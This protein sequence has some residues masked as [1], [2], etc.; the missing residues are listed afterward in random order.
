MKKEEGI[1]TAQLIIA[2]VAI[3]CIICV[4]ITIRKSNNKDNM[5][6]E[7]SKKVE[8]VQQLEY[9]MKVNTFEELEDVKTVEGLEIR[10]IQVTQEDGVSVILADI[11]NNTAEE[12]GGFMVD[13]TFTDI[14]GSVIQ[15]VPGYIKNLQAGETTQLN[16]SGTVELVETYNY[17]I[18]KQ[19]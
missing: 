17:T 2:V 8:T 6:T 7:E 12:K 11:T 15:T 13:I 1:T 16:T 14:E 9:E 18:T 19:N 3:I 4:S 5:E 10:N